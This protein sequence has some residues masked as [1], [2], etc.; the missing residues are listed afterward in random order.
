[1]TTDSTIELIR[2]RMQKY[3]DGL[4]GGVGA[5]QVQGGDIN[6]DDWR[7]FAETLNL[8]H[9]YPGVNGVG[10]IHS[11][12]QDELAPYLDEQ[13]TLRPDCAIHPTH[14][15]TEYLPITYIEPVATNK[16][17]VGLEMAHANNRYA[18]AKRERD[19]GPS[20]IIG[21]ITLVQDSQHTP[22]FLFYV[23]YYRGSAQT[24][25]EA[26]RAHFAAMVYAPFVV[27]KLLAKTLAKDKRHIGL[28]LRDGTE[29]DFDPEPLFQ[30]VVDLEFYGRTWQFD[31]WC[32]KSFHAVARSTQPITTLI[33]G[34]FINAMLLGLF[35]ML[36]RANRKAV[37]LT[38]A[39]ELKN[40]PWNAQTPIWKSLRM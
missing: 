15:E 3:E 37:A 31:I 23:P 16:E 20:K 38:T 17:T 27:H 39:Y 2:E 30:R 32:A 22:G 14:S 29:E 9:K 8:S 11:V 26:R 19:S 40:R 34:L 7:I 33:G 36:T 1:M 28:R 13:R 10:V 35:I 25:V 21:P 4:W 12:Q 6:H 24:T 5:I 18:A